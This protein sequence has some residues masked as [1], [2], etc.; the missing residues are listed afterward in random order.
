M[1]AVYKRVVYMIAPLS[2]HDA[3]AAVCGV[4]Q[5]CSALS[6][7]TRRPL[8][9][10]E[11]PLV[12]GVDADDVEAAKTQLLRALKESMGLIKKADDAPVSDKASYQSR[13][14]CSGS[15]SSA[16]SSS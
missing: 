10:L 16:S 3:Q 14:P 8:V 4:V 12:A 2:H 1:H 11:Y 5:V 13:G 7:R 15:S 9:Q 6:R